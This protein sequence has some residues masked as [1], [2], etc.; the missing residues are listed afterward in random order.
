MTINFLIFL[1]LQIS[2]KDLSW[3]G[4]GPKTNISPTQVIIGVAVIAAIV[5]A[6]A[7]VNS[8][9]KTT[10]KKGTA[11]GSGGGGSTGGGVLSIF[12]LHR[13]ARNLDLD[14]EQT[15]MLDYVFKT[16]QVTDPQK[17]INTPALLDRHF[18]RAYRSIEQ[19]QGHTNETQHK[20]AVLFST[21]NVIENSVLEDMNSTRQINDD[22]KFT[23]M[24][25]KDKLEVHVISTKGDYIEVEAPKNVLGSQ[26]KL[27]KGTKVTVLFFNKSNKG[28]SFETRVTGYS[29]RQG[30]PT[31]Q[32]AHSN[33]LRFLSQR[34]FRRKQVAVACSLCLVIV[35]GTGKKQRLIADKRKIQGSLADVSV[36]GCSIKAMVPVQVGARFKIE[37]MLCE[38]DI[39]ALGQVL[40]TNRTGANTIIH[41]KFLKLTQKS[42]NVINSFVYEYSQQ[43]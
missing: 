42:M 8:R 6:L 37:F 11:A 2:A 43:E 3:G 25:N 1:P 24:I 39:A 34:R 30:H 32:L 10:G 12:A 23:L 29:T 19:T 14:H 20:L 13:I 35:E 21:R 38:V 4:G 31:M 17:S 16:D 7:I 36:G 9:N 27:Q 15:K 40:R 18:R 22:V 41:V 28:F 5:A 33:Q 26:I